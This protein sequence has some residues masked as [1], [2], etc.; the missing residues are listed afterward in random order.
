ML[1]C[2]VGALWENNASAIAARGSRREDFSVAA[3]A[4]GVL[5]LPPLIWI[6]GN[7]GLSWLRPVARYDYW[8]RPLPL[9]T[10]TCFGLAAPFSV[11]ESLDLSTF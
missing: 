6:V 7:L 10:C 4:M 11:P 8:T 5:A 2:L 3:V 9:V 1:L